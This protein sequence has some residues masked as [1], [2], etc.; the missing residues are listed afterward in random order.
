MYSFAIKRGFKTSL[1]LITFLLLVPHSLFADQYK[2]TKVYDGD[3]IKVMKN[4]TEI[5][6]RLVGI[7]APEISEDVRFPGQPYSKEAK[8][9]LD[10]L[11]LNKD[12]K[13]KGCGYQRYNLILGEVF[14]GGK[15]INLIMLR[16]GMAGVYYGENPPKNLDFGPYIKA[17]KESKVLKKGI[18]AQEKNY[19]SP[20]EWRK[21]HRFKS[22]LAII[23]YG[24][25]KE[26]GK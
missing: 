13:I 19:I 6:V 17:E 14:S 3:T 2:V 24:I 22:G 8:E 10:S 7:D 25:L 1:A 11:I 21:G 20:K 4:D 9:Y 16:A 5:I 15:N 18:W 12:V 23:L 26:G